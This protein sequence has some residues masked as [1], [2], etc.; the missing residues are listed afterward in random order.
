M[1]IIT[2]RVDG[3]GNDVKKE[4]YIKI[5]PKWRVVEESQVKFHGVI[6]F[7]NGEKR[8]P[9]YPY[10]EREEEVVALQEFLEIYG[11][12]LIEFYCVQNVDFGH[13]LFPFDAASKEQFRKKWFEKGVL[14]Y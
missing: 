9:V 1:L 14:I 2:I 7:C 4:K 6:F 11:H 8:Y 12:K 10:V 5:A 13:F 3:G